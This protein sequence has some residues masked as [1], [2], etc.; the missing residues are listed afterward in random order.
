MAVLVLIAV[1]FW[2]FLLPIA[3]SRLILIVLNLV[4]WPLW[5][6]RSRR[7]DVI[8]LSH[9]T[10][11]GKFSLSSEYP[12]TEFINFAKSTIMSNSPSLLD[13]PDTNLLPSSVPTFGA[14]S[15]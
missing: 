14:S 1:I 7:L 9:G 10:A 3:P 11:P 6:N 5:Q 15:I 4:A 12:Y 13:T 2:A 8:Y